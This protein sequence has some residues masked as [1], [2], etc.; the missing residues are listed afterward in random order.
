MELWLGLARTLGILWIRLAFAVVLSSLRVLWIWMGLC[1]GRL[2]SWVVFA[3]VLS[4]LL[5]RMGTPPP[6]SS[7]GL[8][9]A[10]HYESTELFYED[11]ERGQRK[12][13]DRQS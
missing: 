5:L 7:R 9:I 8:R 4:G 1:L 12:K 11:E 10:L 2:L 6:S 13:F 3:V